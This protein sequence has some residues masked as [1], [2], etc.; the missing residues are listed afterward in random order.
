MKKKEKLKT[1]FKKHNVKIAYFFGSQKDVGITFLSGGKIKIEKDSDLD[2]GIVFEKLP[3]KI[4]QVY[5]NIYAGISIILQPFNI[6]IVFLQETDCLFQFEAIKGNVIYYE[7]E[8][9][10]DNY[11]EIVIKRA[12]DLSYKKIDFEKDFLEAIKNGYFQITLG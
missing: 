2:I 4:Y 11:E 9:F 5:G 12:A 10:F 7:N 6:D 8:N 1:L 3:E